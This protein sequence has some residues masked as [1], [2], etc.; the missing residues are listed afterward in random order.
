MRTRKLAGQ[1]ALPNR[2]GHHKSHVGGI[3]KIRGLSALGA[4]LAWFAPAAAHDACDHQG[5]T[6]IVFA[7]GTADPFGAT[8]QQPALSRRNAGAVDNIAAAWRTRHSILS[9]RGLVDAQEAARAPGLARQRAAAVTA[10]LIQRGVG[11]GWIRSQ[12]SD[13]PEAAE[14]IITAPDAGLG[15]LGIP[16]RYT[17]Q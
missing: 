5:K 6:T 7:A 14:A 13:H 8:Q 17:A 10:A 11:T 2:R 16:G 15:C 1:A 4:A 3:L 9:V 12:A